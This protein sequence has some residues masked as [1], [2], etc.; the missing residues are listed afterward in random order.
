MTTD[1]EATDSSDDVTDSAPI[2][3]PADLAEVFEEIE[4]PPLAIDLPDDLEEANEIL[5]ASLR[6]SL[7][8]E[9]EYLDSWQRAAAD[10]DNLRKRS[11]REQQQIRQLAAE[12]VVG[13]LLPTL[14][15]FEVAL[16]LPATTDNEIKLLE[17]MQATYDLLIEVLGREGLDRVPGMGAPFDPA[18]HDAVSQ[19]G[20]GGELV[21]I[22]ELRRGYKLKDK[23]IR[24][25]MVAVGPPAE[26][27][28]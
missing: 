1:H 10:F 18:V 12:R 23:V 16:G 14:D 17:G 13:A 4:L 19:M 8:Q 9:A 21:I 15:S 24:P 2:D 3:V 27:T 11:L 22:G 6:Q 25:A 5:I 26:E 20:E 28:G 7:A